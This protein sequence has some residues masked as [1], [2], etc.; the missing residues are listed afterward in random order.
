MPFP[1]KKKRCQPFITSASFFPNL[2][3]TVTNLIQTVTNLIQTVTNLI[4]TV[5]NE[6]VKPLK[7]N[8]L[9]LLINEVFKK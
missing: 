7:I 8:N 6:T 5:T 3:Q 4:Q 1:V 2:I 9:Y